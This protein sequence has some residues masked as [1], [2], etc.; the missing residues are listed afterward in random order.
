MGR[1]IVDNK[2][3][4]NLVS[5]ELGVAPLENSCFMSHELC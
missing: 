4:T 5:F 1:G 2:K 3:R